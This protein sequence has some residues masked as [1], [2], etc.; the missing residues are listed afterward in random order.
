MNW[1]HLIAT[2]LLAMA[3]FLPGQSSAQSTRVNDAPTTYAFPEKGIV[4][5]IGQE[6]IEELIPTH[7]HKLLVVNFWATWCAPCVAELPYFEEASRTYAADGVMVAGFSMDLLAYEDDW[8]EFTH[9]T[10]ESRG[11]TFPNLQMDIDTTVT[12]PWFSEKW[13]GALPATFY[14]GPDGEKLGERLRPVEKEELMADIERY[15]EE[16]EAGG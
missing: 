7:G 1:K 5:V 6:E 16:I 10:L 13:Q 4:P 3:A 14:Y 12:V 8:P 11:V 15:L 9:K 2:V